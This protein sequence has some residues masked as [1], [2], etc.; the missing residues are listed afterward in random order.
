VQDTARD[1]LN[2][3]LDKAGLDDAE[4]VT[5]YYGQDTE[6]TE[7]E[8]CGNEIREKY[9]HLQV[10]VVKGGQPHYHYIVSVE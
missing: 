3:V 2:E 9:P 5:L 6:E 1:V 7:A 4:I 8:N 10:E